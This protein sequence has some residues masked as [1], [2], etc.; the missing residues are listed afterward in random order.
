MRLETISAEEVFQYLEAWL[1]VIR[2]AMGQSNISE[3]ARLRSASGL[4]QKELWQ[5]SPGSLALRV[6]IDED[7]VGL[8]LLS[9]IEVENRDITAIEI[10]VRNPESQIKLFSQLF[11]A[12]LEWLG[13]NN[14]PSELHVPEAYPEVVHL[15][16]AAGFVSVKM[17][18]SLE[19]LEWRSK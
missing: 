12:L 15:Y 5:P 14:F 3:Q 17:N 4:L 6:L 7:C 19:Y 2:G 13:Y 11:P 9:I 18:G 1:Q 10:V 16:V 8:V